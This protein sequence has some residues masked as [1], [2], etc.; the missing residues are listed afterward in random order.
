MTEIEIGRHVLQPHRQLLLDGEHVHLG[1]RAL[2][3]LSV[4]AEA[5]GE[6]VTKDELMEAVW[7]DVT[8]EEN[9]L[10]VHVTALRKA[11][12]EDAERVHTIRGI[13][14]LLDLRAGEPGRSSPDAAMAQTLASPGGIAAS[15]SRV[16]RRMLLPLFVVLLLMVMLAWGS[17][18]L[19][20]GDESDPEIALLVSTFEASDSGNAEEV[21]LARG[22]TD[23][24][25]ARLRQVD[26][27]LIGSAGADEPVTSG[28]F[29]RAH[30][31]TGSVARN[32]ERVRVT[33]R[34]REPNGAVLWTDSYERELTGLFEVQELIA[35]SI[36]EALSVS[37]DVG[38]NSTRYGGTSNPE[39]FAAYLQWRANSL[40]LDPAVSRRYLERAIELD[41]NYV[42]ALSALA[43]N[44]GIAIISSP[45]SASA[46]PLIA[47]MDAL[48][49]RAIEVRPGLAEAHAARGWYHVAVRDLV[50]ADRA[51]ERAEH[52]DTGKSPEIE[53]QLA[54]FD[55]V[56]GRVEQALAH[57]RSAEMIDPVVRY[58]PWQ[59]TELVYAGQQEQ[60][61]SLF[62]QLAEDPDS[63]VEA[64]VWHVATGLL[65]LG[66]EEDAVTLLEVNGPAQFS[67]LITGFDSARLAQMSPAELRSEFSTLSQAQVASGHMILAGYRNEPGL[68]LE[69][70]R[71]AFSKPGGNM[72]FTLWN[73]NLATA[74]RTDEFK[75]LVTELGLAEAWRASDNWGDYC[76][77]LSDEDFLCF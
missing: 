47:R 3:I 2:H 30:A 68:A 8:V 52:L 31:I 11:L 58:N 71:I 62:L 73:P 40:D 72:L 9:A 12:G 67:R 44:M 42:V 76:Q 64:H 60:A 50:A 15:G 27:L 75:Q 35:A 43:Q 63:N 59:A 23:E 13:G 55:L 66:R 39:A 46:Q 19:L 7:G 36:A 6:I 54:V 74:R 10:Q 26:G 53:S 14:Y 16:R 38:S 20:G 33:V 49:S 4:L 34:L 48:S 18:R 56:M 41:P 1:P 57:Q 65:S 70:A 45:D 51:F 24:L 77:P 5:H 37:L 32:G 29:R 69:L 61:H 28:P 21:A 22:I 17:S 25:I